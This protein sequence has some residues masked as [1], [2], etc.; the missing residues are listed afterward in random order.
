MLD[1]P[2]RP[3]AIPPQR[4]TWRV[5]QDLIVAGAGAVAGGVLF[6]LVHQALIDDAYITLSYARNVAFH[7][8]WGLTEQQ[9]SN[10]ATSPL[11]VLLLAGITALVRHPL[12][13]VA[14]VLALTA[15]ATAVWSARMARYAGLSWVM[16]VLTVV[17][18]L[19]N[20]LLMSTIGLET[21]TGAGL[22]VGLAYYALVGR[23]VAAGVV[24]GLLVL[25]RPDLLVFS[26]VAV[27]GV[28]ALRRRAPLVIGVAVLVVL[29]WHVVSWLLLGSALPDTFLLKVGEKWGNWDVTTG[30]LLYW[31]TYPMATALAAAP[32]ALGVV[33]LAGWVLPGMR[34]NVNVPGGCAVPVVTG[35]GG[36]AHLAVFASLGTAPYHWYYGPAVAA[37]SCCAAF[38]AAVL[39]VRAPRPLGVLVAAPLAVLAFVGTGFAFA[40]GVPWTV[41]P[42]TT[43]WALPGEYAR[44]GADL[45]DRSPGRVISSPGEI[46]TLA[47]FCQ[48]AI[49]DVFSDRGAM[50]EVIREREQ[51]VGPV[52]RWLLRL[53]YR[54][55]DRDVLR[56]RPDQQLRYD[57]GKR[58]DG[59][60]QWDVQ[61]PWNQTGRLVL[62]STG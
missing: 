55:S 50:N 26:L 44:V 59:P 14:V 2:V 56:A 45:A 11:N 8:H 62:E 57:N 3:E 53:N 27:L 58:A 15:A 39:L 37:L 49:V 6:L 9:T 61:S 21:L 54:Y 46:G 47:Y 48:C 52:Q 51:E 19:A 32:A 36:L 20:P 4:L 38:T 23:P 30:G 43:N 31:L 13:A 18:L 28:A 35:V 17:A 12:V 5:R 42:F 34:R 33:C 7:L 24:S 1:T 10:T 41:A 29:P 16:P 40:R 25:A 60:D 22:V